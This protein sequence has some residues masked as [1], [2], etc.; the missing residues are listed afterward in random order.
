MSQSASGY[1]RDAEQAIW[2]AIQEIRHGRAE[3][4]LAEIQ[5]SRRFAER[6]AKVILEV[7]R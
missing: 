3:E 2:R 5:R 4:A 7:E 1:L 6:A